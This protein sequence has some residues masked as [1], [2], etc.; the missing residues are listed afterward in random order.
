[1]CPQSQRNTNGFTCY[2]IAT[3]DYISLVTVSLVSPAAAGAVPGFNF[4][5]DALRGQLDPRAGLKMGL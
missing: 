5:G 1:M 2:G 4:P 3:R